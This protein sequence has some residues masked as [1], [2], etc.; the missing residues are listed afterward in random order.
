MTP[1]KSC[2]HLMCLVEPSKMR[3]LAA[4]EVVVAGV[5]KGREAGSRLCNHHLLW[6][7][8]SPDWTWQGFGG[9]RRPIRQHV[10]GWCKEPCWW[11]LPLGALGKAP[12]F[13]SG[14]RWTFYLTDSP[15][16]YVR[17]LERGEVNHSSIS[18]QDLSN[19]G[20]LSS[21]E[22]TLG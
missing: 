11:D 17:S 2:A 5:R 21:K 20:P 18:G 3:Q 1:E 7:L 4:G 13:T 8:R 10:S 16:T 12:H 22:V 6:A 19:C 15:K 9:H 14:K